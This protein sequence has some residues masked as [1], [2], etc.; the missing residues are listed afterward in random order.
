MILHCGSADDGSGGTVMLEAHV[1]EMI[2]PSDPS[3][4]IL[5]TTTEFCVD[6]PSPW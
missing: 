4:T 1:L 6:A 2:S 3:S 5:A